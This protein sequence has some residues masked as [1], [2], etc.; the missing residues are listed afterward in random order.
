MPLAVDASATSALIPDAREFVDAGGVIDCRDPMAI[1]FLD[2]RQQPFVSHLNGAAIEAE[3]ADCPDQELRSM[4]A[5]GVVLKAGIKPQIVVIGQSTPVGVYGP[6]VGPRGGHR[7]P[8]ARS[9]G[10]GL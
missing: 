3:L 6:G 2:P 5:G 7:P 10:T 1:G 8:R 9:R 4:V